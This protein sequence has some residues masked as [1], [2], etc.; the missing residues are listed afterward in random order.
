VTA[1]ARFFLITGLLAVGFAAYDLAA[2]YFYQTYES[3][4]FDAS[5]AL[6]HAGPPSV[7][8]SIAS[9]SLIGK[10]E[11]P[12]LNI[13]A[14]VKE[15]VDDRTLNVAA[16]HIPN[17]ALPGQSGNIGVAAH[18]DSLSRNLKYVRCFRA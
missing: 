13:S 4:E 18:R 5:V 11:I 9:Q 3:R 1:L 2:R 8:E 14:M 17:I 16:G 6:R 15:G 7:A 12:R 10:I